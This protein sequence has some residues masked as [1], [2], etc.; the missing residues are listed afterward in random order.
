MEITI[1]FDAQKIV[2]KLTEFG[3]VQLP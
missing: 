1:E 2:G 3:K